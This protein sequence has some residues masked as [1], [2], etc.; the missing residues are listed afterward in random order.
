[1]KDIAGATIALLF[2]CTVELSAQTDSLADV[3]PL[4][5]GNQWRF[6]YT[7]YRLEPPMDVIFTDSGLVQYTVSG[8]QV[9]NDSTVWNMVQIRNF[10]YCQRAFP[11]WP[12]WDTCYAIVDT[13]TRLLIERHAGNHQLY[14]GST[15]LARRISIHSH[16][17]RHNMHVSI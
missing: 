7:T 17:D 15:Q 3:F 1:M 11:P 2:V 12:G 4:A 5:I 6:H 9:F 10:T 14:I 13:S 16:L 8:R